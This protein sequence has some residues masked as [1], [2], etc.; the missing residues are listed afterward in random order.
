MFPQGQGYNGLR[1]GVAWDGLKVREQG[2]GLTMMMT[3]MMM[4][5]LQ[6]TILRG[7]EQCHAWICHHED[8]LCQHVAD[9]DHAVVFV[10]LDATMFAMQGVYLALCLVYIEDLMEEYGHMS[11]DSHHVASR[12]CLAARQMSDGQA[13][14]HVE[15]EKEDLIHDGLVL[16]V[17]GL[18]LMNPQINETQ[19]G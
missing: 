6:L 8:D 12:L 18:L 9:H 4:V 14:H 16:L 19:N 11:H 1:L 5:E 3:M 15:V 10:A 7:D 13:C 2:E 17:I